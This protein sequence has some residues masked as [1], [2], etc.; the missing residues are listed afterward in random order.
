MEAVLQT[1]TILVSFHVKGCL[2]G[3]EISAHGIAG[4]IPCFGLECCSWSWLFLSTLHQ[5]DE[6]ILPI[7]DSL[8]P[9][10]AVEMGE[11]AGNLVLAVLTFL[12]QSIQIMPGQALTMGPNIRSS[13][14]NHWLQ[15]LA[16][17]QGFDQLNPGLNPKTLSSPGPLYPAAVRLLI[18]AVRSMPKAPING[19]IDAVRSMLLG[20]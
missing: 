4:S 15:E 3:S 8:A 16:L 19:T 14:T 20:V 13:W 2:H 7:L 12:A 11:M 10:L 5:R 1:A 17:F 6:A 18:S 9:W